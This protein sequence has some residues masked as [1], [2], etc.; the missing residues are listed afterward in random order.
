MPISY[1][2]SC[3]LDEINIREYRRDNQKWTVQRNWQ[4]NNRVH[5]EKQSKNT[6]QY[7]GMLDST[8]RKKKTKK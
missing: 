5:E 3:F 6:T 8:M 1:E 4:H 7:T 2:K